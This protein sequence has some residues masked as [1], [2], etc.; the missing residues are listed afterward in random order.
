M[1]P[2]SHS[3]RIVHSISL[4]SLGCI[5]SRARFK[6]VFLFDNVRVQTEDHHYQQ[7]LQLLKY[8]LARAEPGSTCLMLQHCGSK[9]GTLSSCYRVCRKLKSNH[10]FRISLTSGAVASIASVS[11]AYAQQHEYQLQ[12]RAPEC[13]NTV[14]TTCSRTLR[15]RLSINRVNYRFSALA[16]YS[17]RYG[18][19]RFSAMISYPT[20]S[21]RF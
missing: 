13:V 11:L 4:P 12:N 7:P 15:I 21:G 19:N 2:E 6:S 20:G 14:Y 5:L 16:T 18:A 17:I 1:A 9:T 10:A 3:Y 8:W